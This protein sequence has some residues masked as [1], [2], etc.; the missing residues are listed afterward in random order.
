MEYT[1]LQA[2]HAQQVGTVRVRGW[3]KVHTHNLFAVIALAAT[4]LGCV[5]RSPI[6]PDGVGNDPRS[7]ARASV[8]PRPVY[9]HPG[10]MVSV[11][12]IEQPLI[13]SRAHPSYEKLQLLGPPTPFL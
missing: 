3:R 1:S 2:V 4:V 10:T 13:Y 8:W 5:I 6:G 7:F 9:D 12:E 11:L